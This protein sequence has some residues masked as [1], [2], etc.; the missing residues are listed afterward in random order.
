M[1]LPSLKKWMTE[2]LKSIHTQYTNTKMKGGFNQI[3]QAQ[4]LVPMATDV[5]EGLWMWAELP[6][7]HQCP[8]TTSLLYTVCLFLMSMDMWWA[9]YNAQYMSP[10]NLD[11]KPVGSGILDPASLPCDAF[12]GWVSKSPALVFTLCLT[13]WKGTG[14]CF[15]W[16]LF[17][18][19]SFKRNVSEFSS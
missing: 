19:G 10:Y 12:I 13:H 1:L 8:L 9:I 3:S 6:L 4:K 15:F 2:G 17:Q 7:S 18:L 14:A 5:I 11:L 16:F